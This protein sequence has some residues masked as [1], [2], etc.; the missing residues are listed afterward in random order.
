[1]RGRTPAVALGVALAGLALWRAACV[2][3]GPDV[4][5]DAYAHHMIARAIL[6]DPRDLSVHWVWLPLFHYL[7]VPLVALGGTMSDVRWANV[8]LAAAVPV[9]LFGYVRSTSR[10][11][12][13]L[14]AD[15]TALVAA[16]L[17]AACPIAMQMGTTAQSEPLFALLTLGIAIAFERRRYG[18]TAAM[19]GAAVLLRY[20]G[21]AIFATVTAL[22]V[23]EPL[24]TRAR[25]DRTPSA[26]DDAPT[27]A[28]SD[29]ARRA[30]ARR[31]I[32][33]AVPTALILAWAALR[34][35]VDGRWFGF[36]MQTH[37][38]A[39]Q[40]VVERAGAGAVGLA[41][42]ALYYPVYVAVRVLGPA[43]AL[44]PFGVAR[45]WRQQG[46]RFVL[47]LAACL[48]FVSLTWMNRST[49]GLDRHFVAV[50][51]LYATFAA[52]GVA[53]IAEHVGRWVGSRA[54][55]RAARAT[56][57]ALAGTLSIGA[58]AALGV[59]LGVWMT[60][61]RAAIDHGWPERVA[62]GAYVRS[63]PQGPTIFCDDATLEI[64]SG[65]DRRRFD[66]HWIDDSHTWDLIDRTAQ[67]GGV[68]Y[69][70]TWQRKLRDHETAGQVVF[71]ATDTPADESSGVTVMRIL[72]DAGRAA[73]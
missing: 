47:V 37:E 65:L 64:L 2:L 26:N 34:L 48:G 57:R 53:A 35:P 4:D 9:V 63:L 17:C 61:W 10:D 41:R 1:M 44:A 56:A 50:I 39:S 70:A 23:L 33:V 60:F 16:L 25:R 13:A 54:S 18:A 28:R 8:V 30:G 72:P 46:A 6:A 12:T 43:V 66:R 7:Q 45:T 3:A 27:A 21:W 36:L 55:D 22:T 52:Q 31:W 68:A 69:V 29:A 14:P 73:R 15:A 42:D 24:A 11:G 71:H 59:M 19:L 20:E 32:V 58:V 49:L 62:L 51:P 40:A 67:T 5:T 38:F